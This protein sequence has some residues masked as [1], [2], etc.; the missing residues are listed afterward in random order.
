MKTLEIIFLSIGT[1]I[2]VGSFITAIKVPNPSEFQIWVFRVVLSMGGAFFGAALPG[3]IEL[4]GKFGE[5]MIRA[6]GAIVFFLIL[7]L[8]NP[9]SRINKSTESKK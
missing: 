2:L 6:G 1:L 4:D 9:P 3:F 5:V 8:I 7:Y